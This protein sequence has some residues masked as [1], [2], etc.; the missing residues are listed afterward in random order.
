MLRYP[1]LREIDK[2]SSHHIAPGDIDRYLSYPSA[3]TAQRGEADRKAAKKEQDRAALAAW[4]TNGQTLDELPPVPRSMAEIMGD[5]LPRIGG[6]VAPN[7][8]RRAS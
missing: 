6:I 2:A 1:P 7:M 8:G 5:Y 3:S 4:R